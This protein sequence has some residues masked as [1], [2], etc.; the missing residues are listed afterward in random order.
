[1]EL[2]KDMVVKVITSADRLFKGKVVE[3][4]PDGWFVMVQELGDRVQINPS[5]VVA[6]EE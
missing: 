5:H 4:H 6:I 2:Q 1:M 3:I